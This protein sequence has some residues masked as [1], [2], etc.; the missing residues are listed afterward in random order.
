MNKKAPIVDQGFFLT[1]CIRSNSMELQARKHYDTKNSC[2]SRDK[3]AILH[4]CWL[5]MQS[6]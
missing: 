6:Y 5:V 4:W 1:R 2:K 3:Q